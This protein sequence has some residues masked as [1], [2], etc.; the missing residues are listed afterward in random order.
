MPTQSVLVPKSVPIENAVGWVISHGYVVL[1]IDITD[2][3]YRFRQYTPKKTEK[4]YT[5]VLP[6]GVE[7]I[8]AGKTPSAK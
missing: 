4:Y 1:K 7:L 2:K 6:N 3:F 8:V 5:K